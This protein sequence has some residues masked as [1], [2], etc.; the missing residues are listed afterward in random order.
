MLLQALLLAGEGALLGLL[1][2]AGSPHEAAAAAVRRVAARWPRL[3][4]GWRPAVTRLGARR[5]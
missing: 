2:W 3:R 1:Q 4:F 5:W